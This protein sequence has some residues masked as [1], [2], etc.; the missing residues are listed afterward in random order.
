V[1]HYRYLEGIGENIDLE[2][3]DTCQCGDYHFTIDRSEKDALLR[4]PG[5]GLTQSEE[6]GQS[7]KADRFKGG[8]ERWARARCHR[9]TQSKEFDRIDLAAKIFAP[10]PIKFHRS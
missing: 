1:W 9:R 2:F 6:M 7:K 4:V 5:A 3:V 8:M 10:P